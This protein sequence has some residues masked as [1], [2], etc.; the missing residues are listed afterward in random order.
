MVFSRDDDDLISTSKSTWSQMTKTKRDI[1]NNITKGSM[2]NLMS[3]QCTASQ[4]GNIRL[5]SRIP[6]FKLKS[7]MLKSLENGWLFKRYDTNDRN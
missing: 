1:V 7:T 5:K 4:S 3:A 2:S 6:H